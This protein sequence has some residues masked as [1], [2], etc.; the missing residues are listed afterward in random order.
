MTFWI[1]SQA[2]KAPGLG[3][4]RNSQP[5]GTEASPWL[6]VCQCGSGQFSSCWG[7]HG[8]APCPQHKGSEPPCFLPA[9]FSVGFCFMGLTVFRLKLCLS[10]VWDIHQSKELALFITILLWISWQK[11]SGKE[12]IFLFACLFPLE[13]KCHLEVTCC[14]PSALYLC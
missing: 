2:Q 11:T 8:P 14:F 3:N 5:W 7:R 12:G 6:A 1:I 10:A 9:L 4:C 13:V